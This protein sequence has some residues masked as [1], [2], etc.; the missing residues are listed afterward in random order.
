MK[1]GR[2]AGLL[3]ML[4]ACTLF[5]MT[6]L[7]E[8]EVQI[9]EIMIS[10]EVDEEV[11]AKAGGHGFVY[12]DAFIDGSVYSNN[13][14]IELAYHGNSL[15]NELEEYRIYVYRGENVSETA[16]PITGRV[17][18][19]PEKGQFNGKFTLDT[20]DCT[21]W[22]EGKYTIVWISYYMS[23]GK[24]AVSFNDSTVIEI[25]DY[26]RVKDREFVKR[27]YEKVFG[28]QGDAN[29]VND[30]TNKLFTGQT[31]G[32]TTVN[33]FFGSTE[34]AEKNT[35]NE[36]YVNLLYE[37]IFNRPA[38]AG[39]M[40]DWLDT[41]DTGVSRRYVLVQFVRSDEFAQLCADYSIQKGDLEVTENRDK[42]YQVTGFVNRLYRL[43]LGRQPDA[44]GIND[45]TG[46]L[47]SKKETP[48]QVARGFIFSTEMSNKKLNNTEFVTLLYQVM[49]DREPDASG[50]ADWVGRLEK[51]ARREDVYNGFADS[52][53][54]GRIV[55]S[56]GL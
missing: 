29:G 9:E 41:L 36:Q 50:L 13:T 17:Q 4:A 19:F 52:V 11:E 38:D 44:G 10:S 3:A 56:Y 8:E 1:K 48:K 45:W 12:P 54:F 43:A 46:R 31:T 39:G 32:A 33:G 20:R 21:K 47:L 34:F 55:S 2:V 51:G 7:A 5:S 16:E 26:R 15:G 28:R 53:E 40:Q 30:W 6:A 42:N 24:Y 23:E 18:Q 14:Q 25:E 27:L 22:T 35:G 37:A 49:M